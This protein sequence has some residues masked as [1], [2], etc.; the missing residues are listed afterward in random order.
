MIVIQREREREAETQQAEGE[1]GSMHGEPDVEFDPGSP[2][3]RPGPKAGTKPLHHPGIP[4]KLISKYFFLLLLE[5][6]FLYHCILWLLFVHMKAINFCII[7]LYPAT[8]KV[9]VSF[10]MDSLGF[11]RYT[12]RVCEIKFCYFVTILLPLIDFSFLITL[13]NI[14]RIM[15][16]NNGIMDILTWFLIS[17]EMPLVFPH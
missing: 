13:A 11:S 17:V 3:P 4:I 6:G 9:R 16:N 14:I 12:I 1:A 2:G 7:I 8:F 15:V 10:I 5:V